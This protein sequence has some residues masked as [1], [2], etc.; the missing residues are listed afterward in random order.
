MMDKVKADL[1]EEICVII[2]GKIAKAVVATAITT[3]MISK[4][5]VAAIKQISI[6]FFCAKTFFFYR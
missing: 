2:R 1:R 3:V 4:T 6:D 5:S